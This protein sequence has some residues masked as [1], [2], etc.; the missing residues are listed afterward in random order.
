MNQIIIS[1]L[2]TQRCWHIII[3]FAGSS[4]CS[5]VYGVTVISFQQSHKSEMLFM[6]FMSNLWSCFEGVQGYLG[7]II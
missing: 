3:Q 7:N 5:L 4:L 6:G 1:S 2:V